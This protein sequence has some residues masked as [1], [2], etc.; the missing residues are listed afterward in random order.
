MKHLN[1]RLIALLLAL[2]M[3]AALFPVSAFAAER[4]EAEETRSDTWE[5]ILAY[6][7]AHLHKTRNGKQ[8]TAADYAALSGEIAKIVEASEDYKEG[9]CTYDPD[10]DNAMFFWE[11]RD[12]MPQGYSP[13]L[14]AKTENGRAAETD[15]EP[16]RASR[17]DLRG[18]LPS[19]SDIYVLS[20][21]YGIDSS[22]NSEYFQ[23]GERLA[24]ATGGS[25][26]SIF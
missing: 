10:S 20:P 4:G 14:R 16:V 15:P 5:A 22:F 24:E 25:C 12:G 18:G 9:T 19:S 26:Y 7:N 3:L 17:P 23:E 6:E 11:D 1:K 13:A 8:R 2:V 21:W